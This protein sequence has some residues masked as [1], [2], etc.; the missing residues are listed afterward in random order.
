M[1]WG[2]WEGHGVLGWAG[3][4][5]PASL[6]AEGSGG[7]WNV[8]LGSSPGVSAATDQPGRRG[9]GWAP[10]GESGAVGG[11]ARCSLRGEVRARWDA[12]AGELTQRGD[13]PGW[14]GGVWGAGG[15][16]L[17]TLAEVTVPADLGRRSKSSWEHFSKE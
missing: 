5:A 7:T 8:R 11:R 3:K 15:R 12:R 13:W 14:A 4:I 6:Q 10:P 16:K 9:G 1:A 2:P 17:S